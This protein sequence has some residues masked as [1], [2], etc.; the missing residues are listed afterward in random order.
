MRVLF[1]AL[2]WLIAATPLSAEPVA[3]RGVLHA[4]ATY[5]VCTVDLRSTELR[6]FWRDGSGR[7]FG[8]LRAVESDLTGQG[9][10]LLF[11]MNGGMYEADGSPVGL[12]VEGGVPFHGVNTASSGGNFALKPNGIFYWKGDKAGVMETQRF[13]KERPPADFATQ[14]G[15]MLVVDGKLHPAFI[16]GST[17]LKLRN[18]VGVADPGHAIF[19]ISE[20][21]VSFY[22]FATLFRDVLLCKNA[23]F[24]DGSVSSMS[25]PERRPALLS[26]G[27]GP[28]IGAVARK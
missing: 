28:I 7:P 3:C 27:L 15:P 25:T 26:A 6:L 8:S 20:N 19:A 14:S 10:D 16:Q 23:L 2:F 11:A 21:P 9:R 18:G 24:L 5:T 17:S 12:Y 22:D 4:G 13:L 1:L